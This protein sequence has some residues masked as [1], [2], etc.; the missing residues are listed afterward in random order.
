MTATTNDY[1]R[2]LSTRTQ[3]RLNK[4]ANA[5][6]RPLMEVVEEYRIDQAWVEAEATARKVAP[7]V[8]ERTE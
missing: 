3:T 2:S 4:A 6:N 1:Y 7:E 5:E 8:S